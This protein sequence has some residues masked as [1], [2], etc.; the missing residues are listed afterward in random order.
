MS[1]AFLDTLNGVGARSAGPIEPVIDNKIDEIVDAVIAAAPECLRQRVILPSMDWSLVTPHKVSL[2][3]LSLE[4]A[5]LDIP[6]WLSQALLLAGHTIGGEVGRKLPAGLGSLNRL[7]G[8]GGDPHEHKVMSATLAMLAHEVDLE[9]NVTA[10]LVRRLMALSWDEDAL[11]LALAQFCRAPQALKCTGKAF[12]TYLDNLPA[13]RIR[14]SGSS[15]TWILMEA[16]RPAFAVQGWRAEV[17][18][19]TF[20]SALADLMSPPDGIDALAVLLDFDSLVPRDWRLGSADMQ[21]RLADVADI[22][23]DALDAFSARARVPLLISTIPV[24]SAPT[25]GFLDRRHAMGVRSGVDMLNARILDAAERSN[26][27]VVVDADQAL[28]PLAARDQSDARLWYY[29]R[30]AYSAEATRLMAAAFAEAW[31]LL[32][33]GPAK[34]LAIDFDNTLW[35]GV[36]GDDG[37]ERLTC[38]EEF[39]GNVFQAMQRECLRLKGQGLLLVALSKNNSDALSVFE[40]HS[41]MVLRPDDFTAAAINWESK[42]DNIRKLADDLNLGLDSFVFIDDSPHEREAMRRLCPEV[43][44]PE[45]PSDPAERPLWLR[46]LTATWLLRL[47]AEDESRAS[48]Y[49]VER[50]ARDAKA[51]AGSVEAYL[52]SLEQRLVLSFVGEKTVV[53][54]A[55]MHQRTNQFNMTTLRLTEP[56][57]VGLMKDKAGGIAVLGRVMDKFGDHGIVIVATVVIRD[58]EAVIRTLLMSCRVIGREVERAFMGELLRELVRRGVR[59]VSGEY[60]PTPKNAMVRDFYRSCGFEQTGAGEGGTTWRFLIDANDPPVSP[61][62]TTSWEA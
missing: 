23:G 18:E 4:Q 45:M 11:S 35:G 53:R 50:D 1:S 37:I 15:T 14:L 9:P 19:G 43:L 2:L 21:S 25:A 46:R 31:R 10:A 16:L 8:A 62:V 24:P 26:R 47:T 36:Y 13:A 29:G 5:R 20:G 3:L 44:V 27:I 57:I 61:Y 55:Q 32:R 40:R 58:D 54:A 48:L 33:R 39:P 28:V 59:R 6:R 56:D 12:D 30:I 17:T 60:I 34:V 42:P 49:A 41:G 22:L 52:S 7:N 38:G 51:G